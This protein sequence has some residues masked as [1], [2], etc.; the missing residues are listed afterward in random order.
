MSSSFKYKYIIDAVKAN[1]LDEV[2]RMHQNKCP[3]DD[4]EK[5]ISN[6]CITLAAK[7]DIL[8]L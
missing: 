4:P 7:K 1:D 5:H 6:F 8:K 2:K 3:I